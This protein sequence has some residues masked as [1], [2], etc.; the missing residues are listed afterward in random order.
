MSI[1]RLVELTEVGR[2]GGTVWDDDEFYHRVFVYDLLKS[3]NVYSEM[4]Y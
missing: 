2:G 1:G 4:R 3:K